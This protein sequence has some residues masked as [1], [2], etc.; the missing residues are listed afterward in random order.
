MIYDRLLSN[1][2]S[3][4]PNVREKRELVIRT[5]TSSANKNTDKTLVTK[6]LQKHLQ[7]HKNK[8]THRTATSRSRIELH[9]LASE[10]LL[11]Y[12]IFK[13]FANW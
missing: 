10:N 7:K 4:L 13:F 9:P 3:A 1:L 8:Q 5:M 11:S 6:N 2:I 12:T